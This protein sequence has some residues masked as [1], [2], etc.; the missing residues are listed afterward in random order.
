MKSLFHF[1]RQLKAFCVGIFGYFTLWLAASAKIIWRY[2]KQTE[3]VVQRVIAVESRIPTV[4]RRIAFLYRWLRYAIHH[5]HLLPNWLRIAKLLPLTILI[6][7]PGLWESFQRDHRQKEIYTEHY[8]YYY[9]HYIAQKQPL[10]TERYY[11]DL[12]AQR[13]AE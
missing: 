3:H 12:Y 8:G 5:Y 11:A 1:G 6:L 9:S 2:E 7:G 10:E 4:D 13:Y